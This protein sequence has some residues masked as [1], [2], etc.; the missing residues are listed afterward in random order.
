MDSF[1]VMIVTVPIITPVILHMDYDLIWWGL[2]NLVIVEIGLIIPPFGL[3]LFVVKG[4]VPKVPLERLYLGV[5][6]FCLADLV[7]VL[8]LMLF[9]IAA[10]WLPSTMAR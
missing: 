4:M 10:L 1:T 2:I 9:P 7:K 5:L 3:H 8:L 6:P